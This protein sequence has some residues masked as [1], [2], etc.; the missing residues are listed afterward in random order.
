[1]ANVGTAFHSNQVE[2]TSKSTESQA[3]LIITDEITWNKNL[4]TQD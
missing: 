2:G 4:H 1:M 3:Q